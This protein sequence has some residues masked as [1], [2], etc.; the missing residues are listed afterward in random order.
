MYFPLISLTLI[1]PPEKQKEKSLRFHRLLVL[2]YSVTK[3]RYPFEYRQ[4]IRQVVL[5]H[6]H[7]DHYQAFS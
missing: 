7:T 5:L 6:H 1:I 2:H 4:L 3:P